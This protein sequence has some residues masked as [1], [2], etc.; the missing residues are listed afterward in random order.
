MTSPEQIQAA[1][2]HYK[3]FCEVLGIDITK[4]DT[5]DTPMRV[6]KMYANEFLVGQ[7]P[8]DFTPT[9]FPA[10][11][12]KISQLV[13]VA[14]CR[15][16]SLCAHHHLPIVGYAHVCYIPG[17]SLLGLSKL[18]RFV[19]WLSAK[20]TVQ[21]DLTIEIAKTIQKTINPKFI[22]VK[23]TAGHECMSCR[24]VGSYEALTSTTCFR[25][26]NKDSYEGARREFQENIQEWYANKGAF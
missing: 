11:S 10:D 14:G 13:T 19:E 25:S 21:E 15:F 18:P 26:D 16:V 5:I 7:R 24:G 23:L 2:A 12:D 22:G 17:E 9:S 1:A 4:A 20:P 6:A 3:D 8:M